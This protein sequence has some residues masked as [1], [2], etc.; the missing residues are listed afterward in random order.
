MVQS[1][2]PVVFDASDIIGQAPKELQCFGYE[3]SDLDISFKKSQM[4]LS[5]YY[6][7]A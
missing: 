4:L 1:Y 7:T 3:M 5:A 6:K 2:E